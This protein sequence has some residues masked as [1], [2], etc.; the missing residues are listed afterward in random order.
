MKSEPNEKTIVEAK[1]GM[2]S[3][4]CHGPASDDYIASIELSN[5]CRE[6]YRSRLQAVEI[7]KQKLNTSNS[8]DSGFGSTS[9]YMSTRK[10]TG[11]DNA[12]E[13]LRR[14]MVRLHIRYIS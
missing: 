13:T 9:D 8:S 10:T 4:G 14:E 7:A 2:V 6:F 1:T 5:K 11:V 12:M 3:S